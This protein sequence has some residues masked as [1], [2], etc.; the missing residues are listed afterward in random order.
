MLI[1]PGCGNTSSIDDYATNNIESNVTNDITSNVT[2][3][4][5][6]DTTVNSQDTENPS[7]LPVLMNP[8]RVFQKKI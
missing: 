8:S 3:G 2:D 5:I 4:I 6:S 1:V 7:N